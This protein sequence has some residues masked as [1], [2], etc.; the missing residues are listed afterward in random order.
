MFALRATYHTTLQMTPMQLIF[1][2]DAILNIKVQA[3][4]QLIQQLKQ[5]RKY[6]KA[7]KEK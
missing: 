1:N 7:I 2:S 4:W 6:F 5:K 3:D